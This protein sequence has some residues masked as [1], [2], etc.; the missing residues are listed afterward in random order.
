MDENFAVFIDSGKDPYFQ[1]QSHFTSFDYAQDNV[2]CKNLNFIYVTDKDTLEN[3]K[4]ALKE[5]S[6]R[7]IDD[8]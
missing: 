4:L 1:D 3:M 2:T 7:N 5:Q 6:Q 8:D